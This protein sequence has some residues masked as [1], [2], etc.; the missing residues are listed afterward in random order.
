MLGTSEST[1][2][3]KAICKIAPKGRTLNSHGCN[4]WNGADIY[5]IPANDPGGVDQ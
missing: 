5:P 1:Y 2:A 4:P 3:N